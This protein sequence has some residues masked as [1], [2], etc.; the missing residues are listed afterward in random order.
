MSPEE[1]SLLESLDA[2]VRSD[3]VRARIDPIVERVTRKRAQDPLAA[4]AWE[5]IPLPVYGGSVPLPIQS[6]WVFILRAGA[7]TGAERHPNSQQRMMSY[8]G[9]GDLQTGG[10][11]QW[12][13]HALVSEGSA[14]LEERWISVPPNT[15]HQAVV[16]G[17]D[18]VV[19]SFHTA[20]AEELIEERPDP[21]DDGRTDR[22]T[23][24][25]PG[26]HSPDAKTLHVYLYDAFA[27]QPFAGNVAGVVLDAARLTAEEMQHIAAE[28]GAPTTGFLVGVEPGVPPSFVVRYFTPRQ[29][30]DLCG[31]VTVALFTALMDECRCHEGTVRIRTSAGELDVRL[32]KQA[33]GLTVA[34]DQRLPSFETPSADAATIRESLGSVLLHGCLPVEIV[35]TGLRHLVVPFAR[36]GDLSELNPDVAALARLSRSVRVD[37]VAAFATHAGTPHAVR[38]RDFCPGIGADEE[39]ASGTTSGA[40]ACY[41]MKHGLL[42]PGQQGE[43]RVLVEQ[44]VEM[45]RP[46]HIEAI[47]ALSGNEVQRVCVRGR[48]VRTL[49][50]ELRLRR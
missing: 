22:R 45:G 42:F 37:T 26:K 34:M 21:V 4:M 9:V 39:P 44:G 33:Q 27:D 13:S 28:L 23:Y 2:L 35:S 43:A 18:W 48:A 50:G 3:F 14:A 17:E 25:A 40:L 41:L 1:R 11:G 47:V 15:W 24:L 31:H 6:S 12:Q 32:F 16:P 5:P 19:V 29:E 46:S 49:S 38:L 7:T 10:A 30:I 20:P 36:I 8:R